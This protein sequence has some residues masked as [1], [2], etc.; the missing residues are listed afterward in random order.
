MLFRFYALG[1]DFL[2]L[3]HV[4]V[5]SLVLSLLLLFSLLYCLFISLLAPLNC[6]LLFHFQLLLLRANLLLEGLL[7]D[8]DALH[9]P[10]LLL[11]LP[12]RSIVAPLSHPLPLLLVTPEIILKLLIVRLFIL[13]LLLL[14]Q[15]VLRLG[16]L[17]N[18]FGRLSSLQ[19][20]LPLALL[21][22]G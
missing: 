9:D 3:V 13:A 10:L 11:P 4:G 22:I 16:V 15:I 2:D 20:T 18:L 8:D 12:L 1:F 21:F 17:D 7:G 14:S 6:T 5:H 19:S